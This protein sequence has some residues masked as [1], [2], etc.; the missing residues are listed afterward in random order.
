VVRDGYGGHFLARRF[1]EKLAGFASP[2][3]QTEIGMNV[4][5]NELRLPHGFQF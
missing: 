5:M 2:V 1:V 3:Q 4:Q